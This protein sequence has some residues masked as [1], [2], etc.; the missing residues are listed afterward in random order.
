MRWEKTGETQELVIDAK[1]KKKFDEAITMEEKAKIVK[2]KLERT[3]I[4]SEQERERVNEC[5]LETVQEFQ[6]LGISRNYVKLL[7]NQLAMI[8]HRLEGTTGP[9]TQDLRETK[10]K[11]EKEIKVVQE[12]L[13]ESD[14]DVPTKHELA[15]TSLDV[16]SPATRTE[17]LSAVP[18]FGL[19]LALLLF[20]LLYSCINYS[21]HSVMERNLIEN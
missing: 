5:F 3:K 19:L 15:Y 13:L 10:A 16:E 20:L 9:E 6:T 21:G 7:E 4:I 18:F 8:E 11:L 17:E 12:T 2:E 1:T 14:V